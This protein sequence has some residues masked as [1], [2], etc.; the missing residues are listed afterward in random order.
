M[1][2]ITIKYSEIWKAE[3]E[4]AY[5]KLS[6][7]LEQNPEEKEKLIISQAEWNEGLEAAEA[8]FQSEAEEKALN[9]TQ[10]FLSV[11]SA[12]LNYYKGRAAVLYYQIYLI[13]GSFDI[14]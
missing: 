12:M 7:M 1:R 9:G 8:S 2:K 10:E 13:S 3:S 6:D 4:N 11:D 5:N 14:R